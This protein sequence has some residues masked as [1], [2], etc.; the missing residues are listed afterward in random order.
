MKNPQVILENAPWG[1][2]VVAVVDGPSKA[3]AVVEHL[4]A[5]GAK[6]YAVP[7]A[8]DTTRGMPF[9]VECVR[10]PS[11]VDAIARFVRCFPS[12]MLC[13]GGW[14]SDATDRDT[15]RVLA[16]GWTEGDAIADAKRILANDGITLEGA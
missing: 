3:E 2:K 16:Q 14:Q 12:R 1:V 4:Q 13:A 9:V 8:W 5:A 15:I 10:A 6:A 7:P 11:E